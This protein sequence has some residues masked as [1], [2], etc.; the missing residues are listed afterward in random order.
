MAGS[1]AG[2]SR[3]LGRFLDRVRTLGPAAALRVQADHSRRR[4]LGAHV[5]DAPLLA[6]KIK[7][8]PHPFHVRERSSDTF[9]VDEVFVYNEYRG[10][11]AEEDV[12]FVV[13][14]GANIGCTAV[15]FLE[16][17]PNARVIAFE[18][19][20][21]NARVCRKNVEPY[22]GRCE[23]RQLGVWSEETGLVV[24]RVGPGPEGTNQWGYE[25]RPCRP[26][27]APEIQAVTLESVL[28]ESPHGVIDL[29]KIDVEK[30]ERV[31]FGANTDAWL[32]HVRAIAIELHDEACRKAYH[33]AVEPLG[34]ETGFFPPVHVSRRPGVAPYPGTRPE[35]ATSTHDLSRESAT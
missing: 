3:S 9:V 33:D 30:S 15:Y 20:A 25:V 22:G 18:P 35:P 34:F 13:D 5:A 28:R 11:A 32:P 7:G 8:L 12:R 26:G 24:E 19:D 29:L 21:D 4:S 1:I 23:V 17:Y 16:K 14:C 10:V 27:E 31:I 6:L 2:M